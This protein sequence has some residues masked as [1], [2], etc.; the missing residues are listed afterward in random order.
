MRGMFFKT[1]VWLMPFLTLGGCA[2]QAGVRVDQIKVPVVVIQKCVNQKDIP[3]QPKSLHEKA[4][5]SDLE[6]ALSWALAKIDEWTQYGHK[7]D[8][9]L[10]G[11]V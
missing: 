2:H 5:P 8:P 9:I 10:K 6:T 7:V 4:A 11:C 1:V 3:L